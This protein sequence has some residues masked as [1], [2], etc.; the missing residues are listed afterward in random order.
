MDKSVGWPTSLKLTIQQQLRYT[1][2]YGRAKMMVMVTKAWWFEGLDHTVSHSWTDYRTAIH[3]LRGTERCHTS[4][5]WHMSWECVHIEPSVIDHIPIRSHT[6]AVL[7][8]ISH[9]TFA[10]TLEIHLNMD[11]GEDGDEDGD[12]D[13]DGDK[14]NRCDGGWTWVILFG[15]LWWILW[16]WKNQSNGF[17]DDINAFMNH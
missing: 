8:H 3:L 17:T 11:K 16:R 14:R 10:N 4:M 6:L 1:H 13:G 9:S 5:R 12:G 2:A 15:Y 7:L